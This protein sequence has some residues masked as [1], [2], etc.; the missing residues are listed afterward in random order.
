MNYIKKA[1]PPFYIQNLFTFTV[2]SISQAMLHVQLSLR[3]TFKFSMPNITLLIKYYCNGLRL[4]KISINIYPLKFQGFFSM[5]KAYLDKGY[6][7]VKI[8]IAKTVKIHTT[9]IL[10]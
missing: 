9:I 6:K 2:S 4:Q 3:H 10:A 5:F 7:D 1:K 8:A